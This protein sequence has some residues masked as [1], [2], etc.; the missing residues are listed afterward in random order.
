M[1]RILYR[2]AID[3]GEEQPRIGIEEITAGTVETN[4]SG[5]GRPPPEGPRCPGLRPST[6]MN[7]CKAGARPPGPTQRTT[8]VPAGGFP[9]LPCLPPAPDTL[10]DQVASQ[11]RRVTMGGPEAAFR[12]GCHWPPAR[13]ISAAMV[14]V[15]WTG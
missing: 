14:A 11:V 10:D 5:E 13:A 4:T 15:M 12:S 2:G 6:G 8:V 3:H 1:S 7:G 9:I